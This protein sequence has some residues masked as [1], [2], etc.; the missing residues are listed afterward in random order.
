MGHEVGMYHARL[1]YV[2]GEKLLPLRTD[3]ILDSLH[4]RSRVQQ[5]LSYE[6]G[7]SQRGHTP[8]FYRANS[9][10]SSPEIS[11]V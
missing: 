8:S 3:R 1:S 11:E 7:C 2:T 10:M 5:S 4:E 6:K 9:W